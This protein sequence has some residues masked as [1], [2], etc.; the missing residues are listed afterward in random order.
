MS[1]YSSLV[2]LASLLCCL[3]LA[4][5]ARAQEGIVGG[6][7]A[8]GACLNSCLVNVEELPAANRSPPD[9][10]NRYCTCALTIKVDPARSSSIL[11]ELERQEH[12]QASCKAEVWPREFKA[13]GA[14]VP[15]ERERKERDEAERRRVESERV[16]NV[17]EKA[18]AADGG[19]GLFKHEVRLLANADWRTDLETLQL[20][21][22]LFK[23]RDEGQRV[24]QCTYGPKKSASGQEALV[25]YGFW[26]QSVP[27]AIDAML[28]IDT[29]GALQYLGTTPQTECPI[30]DR[31][32]LIARQTAMSLYRA[33][34]PIVAPTNAATGSSQRPGKPAPPASGSGAVGGTTGNATGSVKERNCASLT[35]RIEAARKVRTEDNPNASRNLAALERTY[36]R[37]GCAR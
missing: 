29:R 26:Y 30:S 14:Y 17:V 1:S 37:Q 2:R 13:P 19:A 25:T 32:A 5:G 16:D 36:A 24:I 22:M 20:R 23:A 33:S 28:R 18:R 11:D 4:S 34:Q 10:C 21:Q 7:T 9:E 12:R 3:L 8:L 15:S 27:T 35:S 6:Y 31:A